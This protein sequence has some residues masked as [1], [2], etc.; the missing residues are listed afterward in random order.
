MLILLQA[1]GTVFD[2]IDVDERADEV[3]HD[4]TVFAYEATED[5]GNHIYREVE[6]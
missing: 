4:E 1:D 6:S 5:N 2:T 3:L